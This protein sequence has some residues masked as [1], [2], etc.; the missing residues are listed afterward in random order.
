MK[1][2]VIDSF[3]KVAKSV[4]P[5]GSSVWLYGSRARGDEKADSDWDLLILVHK[6]AITSKDEDEY[7]YPFV[8][9]GW[10]NKAD[11]NPLLYTFDEW[12]KRIASPFFNNV[13]HDKIVII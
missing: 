4:L 5:E 2:K 6:D 12:A 13:E 8:L 7:S 3:R 11:V 9:W 1:Q 10:K